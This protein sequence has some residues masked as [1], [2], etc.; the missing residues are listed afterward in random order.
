MQFRVQLGSSPHRGGRLSAATQN[1]KEPSTLAPL[2]LPA[3]LGSW[4]A[5][6]GTGDPPH[7]VLQSPEPRCP[8]KARVGV[9]AS[10]QERGEPWLCPAWRGRPWPVH[11][12]APCGLGGT[13]WARRLGSHP[14][15]SAPAS[16]TR[17]GEHQGLG[18]GGENVKGLPDLGSWVPNSQHSPGE[19]KEEKGALCPS[20]QVPEGLAGGQ[21]QPLLA[22][23]PPPGRRPGPHL[24]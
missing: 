4:G 16:G 24:L 9:K 6:R 10:P 18:G 23:A 21:C 8:S 1:I 20:E 11:S 13:H 15:H 3:C 22:L 17:K 5:L 7:H 19:E 2:Q 14:A 12:K